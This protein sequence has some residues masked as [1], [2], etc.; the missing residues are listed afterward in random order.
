M[1]RQRAQ[2]SRYRVAQYSGI[3]QSYILRLETGETFIL[4]FEYVNRYTISRAMV[5]GV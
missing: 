4:Y 3:D 2:K 5:K 1:L